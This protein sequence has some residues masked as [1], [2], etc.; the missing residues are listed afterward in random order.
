[1]MEITRKKTTVY[2][3]KWVRRDFMEMSPRYRAI[4]SSMRNP[5]T[6]CFK[7]R[8]DFI[9]GEMMGLASFGKHGNKVICTPCIDDDEKGD[10]ATTSPESAGEQ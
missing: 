10:N 6:Q 1:M 9:D 8:H 2:R 3:S 4:R 7:C 5:M